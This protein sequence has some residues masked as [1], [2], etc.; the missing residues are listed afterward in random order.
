LTKANPSPMPWGEDELFAYLRTGF[1]RYHGSSAGPMAPVVRD[2]LAKLPES[3]VRAIATYFADVDG[4]AQ[5]QAE[6]QPAFERAAAANKDTSGLHYDPASRF[7]TAAC[8]SCHY[9]GTDG[10]NAL[11][12]DLLLNSAVGLDEPTNLIRVILYGIDAKGGIPGVVMPGF[13]GWSD[14]DVAQLASYLRTT[15]TAKAPWKDLE[16]KVRA[17]RAEGKD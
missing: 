14:A 16:K 4:A 17:I 3:D 5:R 7:Y 15:R 11:R 10:P 9:N 13:K 8:A 1:S 12:P 6:I 2:G